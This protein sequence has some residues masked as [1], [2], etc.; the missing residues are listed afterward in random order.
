MKIKDVSNH[1]LED[2]PLLPL[3]RKDLHSSRSFGSSHNILHLD[4]VSRVPERT[5][6]KNVT[7]RGLREQVV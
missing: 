3:A 6:K 1:H 4:E 7:M 2:L 5:R